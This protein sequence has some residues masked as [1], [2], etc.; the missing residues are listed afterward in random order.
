MIDGVSFY[1]SGSCV[2]LWVR[3]NQTFFGESA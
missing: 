1:F 2:V 3:I